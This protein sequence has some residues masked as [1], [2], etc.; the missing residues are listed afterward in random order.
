MRDLYALAYEYP[1]M[2]LQLY[3]DMELAHEKEEAAK[4]PDWKK[5]G[6][7]AADARDRLKAEREEAKRRLGVS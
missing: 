2:W 5:A 6:E 3:W 4:Q 1:R 7:T